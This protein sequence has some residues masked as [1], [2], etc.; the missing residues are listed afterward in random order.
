MAVAAAGT[1]ID[2][3]AKG[4]VVIVYNHVIRTFAAERVD[5]QVQRN[6]HTCPFLYS[7]KRVNNVAFRPSVK[8]SCAY[9]N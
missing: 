1:D 5:F 2:R 3:F 9:Y 8:R 7:M 6:S 4:L